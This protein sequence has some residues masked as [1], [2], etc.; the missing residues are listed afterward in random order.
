MRKAIAYDRSKYVCNLRYPGQYFDTETGLSYNYSRDYDP[1]TGRYI[2]SDPIGLS[3]GIDPYVYVA[4]RPTSLADIFGEYGSK[5]G[6]PPPSAALDSF[7]QCMDGCVGTPM[8]VTS[9]TDGK[10]QDPG[11]ARGTSVD[12]QPPPGA[13]A[14]T[15]FCCAGKCG[16]AW[17]LNEG[18]GQQS[19]KYTQ[20]ANNH[21]PP[22]A[23]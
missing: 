11:H 15:V 12:T 17:G 2:E 23:Q 8:F 4:N 1:Q 14:D 9:T 18:A 16:A 13:P 5:P 21:F 20:G 10:H 6:V 7:L 19:F 3:G 22:P